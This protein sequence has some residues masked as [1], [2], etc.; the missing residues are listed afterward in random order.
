MHSIAYCVFIAITVIMLN[1]EV[2]ARPL[3]G[4]A[5]LPLQILMKMLSSGIGEANLTQ[6]ES[7]LMIEYTKNTYSYS[8]NLLAAYALAFSNIK[9][10]DEKINEL[11]GNEH[12]SFAAVARWAIRLKMAMPKEKDE[13]LGLIVNFIDKE[14]DETARLFAINWLLGVYRKRM[15]SLFLSLYENEPEGIIKTEM[16]QT[17]LS[18]YPE[19]K[20]LDKIW[21]D[22]KSTP[23]DLP[24]RYGE[25]WIAILGRLTPGRK[26]N[27][28]EKNLFDF[29]TRTQK[30]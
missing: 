12:V 28:F 26:I 21:L 25:H 19:D 8:A 27:D 7:H 18:L 4:D 30:R 24:D 6:E 16:R 13:C 15:P 2:H 17:I 3:S 23:I 22:I 9:E 1:S 10:A 14:T 11:S 5:E 20:E 29:K